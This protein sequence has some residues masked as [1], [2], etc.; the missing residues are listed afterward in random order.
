MKIF[1][2]N[3]EVTRR[4]ETIIRNQCLDR[5]IDFMDPVDGENRNRFKG[6]RFVVDI[7]LGHNKKKSQFVL[8]HWQILER[9]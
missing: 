1:F 4:I 3:V 5:A 7:A 6:A 8:S 9:R 2:P